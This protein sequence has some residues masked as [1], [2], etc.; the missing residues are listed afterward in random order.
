M[1]VAQLNSLEESQLD[2][3]LFGAHRVPTATI[4]A[5]LWDIQDGQCF[6][7]RRAVRNLVD[8][9]VDHFV[10]WSR[11][12]DDGL[13][14]L[15]VADK[16]CNALK[17]NSLAATDHLRRWAGRFAEDSSPYFQLEDLSERAGWVRQARRSLSVARAIYLRL[18]S[19][20]RL[21]LRDKDFVPPEGSIGPIL[22][23]L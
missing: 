21:W 6:Y 17:S 18:P 3:F 14:N 10:P 1:M 12:P 11:Y 19:D 13:D 9:E 20:A 22:D 5:G 16:R 4:R 15:V 2:E 23:S 7:C 8:A